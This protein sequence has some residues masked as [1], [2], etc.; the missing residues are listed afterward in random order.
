[1]KTTTTLHEDIT[2]VRL[3]GMF[4]NRGEVLLFEEERNSYH[5]ESAEIAL[6]GKNNRLVHYCLE[7][8]RNIMYPY[9]VVSAVIK[10]NIE[11]F[12]ITLNSPLAPESWKIERH[13]QSIIDMP[14]EKYEYISHDIE[15]IFDE[16]KETFNGKLFT[17]EYA[18]EGK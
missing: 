5:P 16:L 3:K 14:D 18:K 13:S 1:M 4:V 11:V 9:V 8:P 6:V 15:A 10:D 2:L 12:K 7:I 17:I